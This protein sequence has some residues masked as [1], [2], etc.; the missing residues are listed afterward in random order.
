MRQFKSQIATALPVWACC[1]LS[2][3]KN[4]KKEP[5]QS[6]KENKCRKNGEKLLRFCLLLCGRY[7]MDIVLQAEFKC[8]FYASREIS[9]Q[10]LYF[11]VVSSAIRFIA[12]L[13]WRRLPFERTRRRWSSPPSILVVV[14]S[15]KRH[16]CMSID[17]LPLARWIKYPFSN[18]Y[19]LA[20][21]I[22]IV[23]LK[24]LSYLFFFFLFSS[25][26]S[27]SSCTWFNEN[28]LIT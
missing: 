5:P 18:C 20:A 28:L 8:F 27:D 11:F 1:P 12:K 17:P 26:S 24:L 9:C 6:G 4:S 22:M 25:S 10:S 2:T 16:T 21:S 19:L 15:C 13:R 14:V 3:H 7:L 23:L